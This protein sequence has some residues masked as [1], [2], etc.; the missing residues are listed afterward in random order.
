MQG[1]VNLV[2]GTGPKVGQVLAEHPGIPLIS[3][4]GSTVV[5]HRISE[6]CWRVLSLFFVPVGHL[7]A[8]TPLLFLDE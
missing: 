1:V 2:F 6:V 4:T 8:R 5:G 7:V 3:F